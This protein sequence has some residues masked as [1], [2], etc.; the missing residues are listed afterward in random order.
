[1]EQIKDWNNFMIAWDNFHRKKLIPFIK[2]ADY[3]KRY[4]LNSLLSDMRS[5][6][7][8]CR[9]KRCIEIYT[10]MNQIVNVYEKATINS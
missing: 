5:A 10:E 7:K 8:W 2:T 3:K 4:K 9:L 6:L 1:M